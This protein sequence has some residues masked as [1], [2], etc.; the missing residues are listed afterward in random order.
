MEAK[1]LIGLLMPGDSEFDDS[2]FDDESEGDLHKGDR[3]DNGN[4]QTYRKSTLKFI[5]YFLLK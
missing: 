2:S 1:Q 5:F 3:Y 4:E